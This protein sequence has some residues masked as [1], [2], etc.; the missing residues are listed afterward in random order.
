[1]SNFIGIQIE[2]VGRNISLLE[3]KLKEQKRQLVLWQRQKWWLEHPTVSYFTAR[4]TWETNYG[5]SEW[6]QELSFYVDSVFQLDNSSIDF[7]NRGLFD[8]Y[9]PLEEDVRDDDEF[10]T[11]RNLFLCT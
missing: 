10:V 8:S 6:E 9:P 5:H 7:Q 2:S 3:S 1:M 4:T 11:Y